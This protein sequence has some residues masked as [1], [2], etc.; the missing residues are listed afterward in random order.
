LELGI[1]KPGIV[2]PG[3][4]KPGF[5]VIGRTGNSQTWQSDRDKRGVKNRNGQYETVMGVD[6]PG[7]VKPGIVKPGRHRKEDVCV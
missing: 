7:V 1:V 4:V 3:I 2:K 5:F 6:E